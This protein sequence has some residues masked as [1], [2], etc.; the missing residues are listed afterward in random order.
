MAEQPGV[1]VQPAR[2]QS[3]SAGPDWSA[4]QPALAN[5]QAQ[6]EITPVSHMRADVQALDAEYAVVER[7]TG[8][9]GGTGVPP[10]PPRPGRPGSIRLGPGR[11]LRP[12]PISAIR[13][14]G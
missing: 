14:R 1:V 6:V 3:I 9:I 10:P 13:W 8:K 11:P 5:R 4:V 12:A 2:L 7:V